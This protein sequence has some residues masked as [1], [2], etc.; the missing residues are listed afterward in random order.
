MALVEELEKIF[1]NNTFDATHI[2][3]VA[4]RFPELTRAIDAEVPRARYKSRGRRGSLNVTAIR[5]ALRKQDQKRIKATFRSW[6]GWTFRIPWGQERPWP[7]PDDRGAY[8]H[9]REMS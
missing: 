5:T 2:Y 9:N 8:G 3:S 4:Y 7:S 1:G 6:G